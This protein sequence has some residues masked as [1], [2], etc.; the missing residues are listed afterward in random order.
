MSYVIGTLSRIP[1]LLLRF[2][3][4]ARAAGETCEIVVADDGLPADLDLSGLGGI[5]RIPC[6]R[7]FIFSRNANA[8]LNSCLDQDVFL[9][10]DDSE[11]TG[12]GAPVR[13]LEETAKAPS[14]GVVSAAVQGIVCNPLQKAGQGTTLRTSP[15]VLCF[16]AVYLSRALINKVGNLDERFTGY[17]Y[18]DDDYCL[19]ARQGGLINFIDPRCVVLHTEQSLTFRLVPNQTA[20]FQE[21]R[22]IFEAKHGLIRQQPV[23]RPKRNGRRMIVRRRR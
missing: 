17:G 4:S 7:P 23:Q 1:E 18:E 5:T 6:P 3:R 19:R 8:V 22:R 16:V 12:T 14:V 2:C 15:N 21:A 10:N 13:F 9:C 20:M 11:M